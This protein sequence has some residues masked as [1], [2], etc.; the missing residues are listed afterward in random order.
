MITCSYTSTSSELSSFEGTKK[1]KFPL[2]K[3]PK[4]I[5]IK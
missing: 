1:V 4:D 3:Y 2:E 5:I